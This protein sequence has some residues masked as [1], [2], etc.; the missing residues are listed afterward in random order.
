MRRAKCKSATR[1]AGASQN[2]GWDPGFEA[3][4]IAL[5]LPAAAAVRRGYSESRACCD[6][7]DNLYPSCSSRSGAPVHFPGPCNGGLVARAPS[8][9]NSRAATYALG[10]LEIATL[11]PS[12]R[13]GARSSKRQRFFLTLLA[14]LDQVYSNQLVPAW[15]RARAGPRYTFIY[16][17]A[18][19]SALPGN[20]KLVAPSNEFR[21]GHLDRV[22][23]T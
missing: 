2:G 1:L 22:L 18:V 7:P 16:A 3:K 8:P 10:P 13:V 9:Q 4:V 15:T 6:G 11:R 12:M 5:R 19:G 23:G 17:F 20:A 21:A 14:L